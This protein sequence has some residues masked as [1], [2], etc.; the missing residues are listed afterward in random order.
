M[1][2]PQ[3]SDTRRK[4]WQFAKI[5]HEKY[6][7]AAFYF[8]VPIFRETESKALSFG[9]GVLVTVDGR[10]FLLTAGHVLDEVVNT[11]DVI[12]LSTGRP[13]VPGVQ[14][15]YEAYA[16]NI[17]PG[18]KRPGDDYLDVGAFR[19]REEVAQALGDR[20]APESLLE[21]SDNEGKGNLYLVLGFPGSNK[22]RS[23]F[24]QAAQARS[25]SYVTSLYRLSRGRPPGFDAST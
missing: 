18:T 19:L 15:F 22:K 13:G 20:F 2:T 4:T 14:L 11:S 1:T 25:F 21:T 24:R 6:G 7:Q 16:T 12:G 3:E 9:S 10:P 17:P 23:W 5:L 8:T